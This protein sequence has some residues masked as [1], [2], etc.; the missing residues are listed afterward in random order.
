MGDSFLFWLSRRVVLGKSE[1]RRLGER[2]ELYTVQLY[3]VSYGFGPVQCTLSSVTF[4]VTYRRKLSYSLEPSIV[5]SSVVKRMCEALIANMLQ[6]TTYIDCSHQHETD[7]FDLNPPRHSG[8][9]IWV[10]RVE[11]APGGQGWREKREITTVIL[12]REAVGK[13]QHKKG[14]KEEDLRG[15]RDEDE[16]DEAKDGRRG[17]GKVRLVGK[18][19]QRGREREREREGERPGG[20][21]SG[22]VGVT[23][24]RRGLGA[25]ELDRGEVDQ[26][27]L[28][29]ES[30]RTRSV[31][32]R[33]GSGEGE[34]EGSG[35]LRAEKWKGGGWW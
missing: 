14:G 35:C 1:A 22:K 11:I 9:Q 23:N 21:A 20:S 25:Y 5:C 16:E 13:S 6:N 3:T 29:G 34:G 7:T 26:F 19:G 10:A 4:P 18:G 17:E 31:H 2:K 33:G 28:I 24:P 27:L 30:T 8:F 15:R 12:F 32:Y